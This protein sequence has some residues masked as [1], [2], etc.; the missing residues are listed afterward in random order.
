QVAVN[1][2][3]NS[4]VVD[5]D[6]DALTEGQIVEAVKAG[7][8][9]AA[10]HPTAGA[11]QKAA[12]ARENPAAQEAAGMRRRLIGSICFLIPL[13]YVSMGHM[14]GL[15]LPGFLVGTENALSFALTQLLLTLPIIYLNRKY[16]Q[17][18]FK[19]LLHGAPNMD[20]LIA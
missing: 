13:M 4:M 7:G 19:T 14:M 1:L 5:Y 12:P 15:P 2:L 8:Y 18:G 9:G 20:S 10:P 3:A 6:E 11:A 16:Y 17:T